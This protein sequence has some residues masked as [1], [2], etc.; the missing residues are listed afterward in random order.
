MDTRGRRGINGEDALPMPTSSTTF[1]LLYSVKNFHEKKRHLAYQF[2][3]CVK[4][5]LHI[6][7]LKEDLNHF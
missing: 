3:F 2:I 1:V 7:Q 5:T 4:Q 6:V